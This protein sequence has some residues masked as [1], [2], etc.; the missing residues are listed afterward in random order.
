MESRGKFQGACEALGEFEEDN[1]QVV[2]TGK[3]SGRA[4]VSIMASFRPHV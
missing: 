2:D 4:Q 1:R 3:K